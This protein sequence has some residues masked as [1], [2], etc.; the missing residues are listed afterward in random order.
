MHHI[1]SAKHKVY[2]TSRVCC[3]YI[4]NIDLIHTTCLANRTY[5]ECI[6]CG[7]GAGERNDQ[8][9]R[10]Q[11]SP[12]IYVCA[13]HTTRRTHMSQTNV[14]AWYT[15]CDYQILLS[16]RKRYP[17]LRRLNNEQEYVV[18]QEAAF[19]IYKNVEFVP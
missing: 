6:W 8:S 9:T 1:F 16:A 10:T 18:Q 11:T 14:F 2:R 7:L 4:M 17:E 13:E 5:K 15:W 12:A 19:T 3:M